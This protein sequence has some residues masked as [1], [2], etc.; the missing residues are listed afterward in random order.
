[1]IWKF[2]LLWRCTQESALT[3]T[4]A[5]EEYLEGHGD[6]LLLTHDSFD[7]IKRLFVHFMLVEVFSYAH[8]SLNKGSLFKLFMFLKFDGR[9]LN[10][11]L[12]HCK[13][14]DIPYLL[15]QETRQIMQL[16]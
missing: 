15:R 7:Y 1:M 14:S 12:Y 16:S 9:S 13:N 10:K 3:L 2:L 8:L 11:Q 5:C 6:Y 4:L